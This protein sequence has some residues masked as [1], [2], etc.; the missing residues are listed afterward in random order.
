MSHGTPSSATPQAGHLQPQGQIV[1]I[2]SSDRAPFGGV[3]ASWIVA[4]GFSATC[5]AFE[6]DYDVWVD[7]LSTGMVRVYNRDLMRTRQEPDFVLVEELRLGQAPGAASVQGPGVFGDIVGLAVDGSGRTYVADRA[8][9]EIRVFDSDGTFLR[10]FGRTGDGPGE[11][12][13]LGGVV[14]HRSGAL[15]AMDVGARRITAFNSSGEVLSTSAHNGNTRSTASVWRAETDTLGF[16][17]ERDWDSP[18]WARRVVKHRVLPDFTLAPVDTIDLPE[19]GPHFDSIPTN[20]R[21]LWSVDPNGSV[22]HGNTNRFLFF[23]VA[24][25]R[26]TTLAVEL[27]RP[28]PLLA[29]RERDSLAAAWDLPSSLLPRYKAVLTLLRVAGDGRVWVW[30]PYARQRW[31]MWEMFDERGHHLGQVGITVA[32]ASTPSPVF[33]DGTVTGVTHDD[34]GAQYVVRLRVREVD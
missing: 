27:R 7:T 19:R 30:N 16:L 34:S 26:D 29:G 20:W 8:S 28:T 5:D 33:G 23:K 6:R 25:R 31:G 15:L 13:A 18:S 32:L 10:R 3:L 2:R 9:Q 4:L 1:R 11:F 24:H 22:W 14:W 12:Q 17:Y 21:P